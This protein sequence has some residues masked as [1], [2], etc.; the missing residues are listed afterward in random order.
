M[1]G[2][3]KQPNGWFTVNNTSLPISE[4]SGSHWEDPHFNGFS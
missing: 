1:Q 4:K 2:C 3:S